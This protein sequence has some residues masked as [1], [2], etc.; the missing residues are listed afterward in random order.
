MPKNV[1]TSKHRK[2][3]VSNAPVECDHPLPSP[4]DLGLLAEVLY[5]VAISLGLPS[6]QA[7]CLKCAVTDPTVKGTAKAMNVRPYTVHTLRSRIF[8]RLGVTTITDALLY[9]MAYSLDD[10]KGRGSQTTVE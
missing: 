8:S 5:D 3:P 4:P 10:K 9:A 1:R 2:H 7:E 6:R